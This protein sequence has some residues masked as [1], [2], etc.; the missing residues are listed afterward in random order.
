MFWGEVFDSEGDCRAF[1]RDGRLTIEVPGPLLQLNVE[2]D[3]LNSQRVVREI[4]GDFSL[5]VNLKGD[6]RPADKSTNLKSV[7]CI[8][9]GIVV[10][11]DFEQLRVSGAGGDQSTGKAQRGRGLRGSPLAASR[12]APARVP[13]AARMSFPPE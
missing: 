11:Q 1:L 8:G 7:P 12:A 9:A 6:F 5:T 10:W 3:K 4:P 13:Q 2:I